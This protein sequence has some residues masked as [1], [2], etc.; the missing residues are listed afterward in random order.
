MF[1]KADLG[2]TG[3]I[4]EAHCFDTYR[5]A[6][7]FCDDKRLRKVELVVR[8]SDEYE[9]VV[10]VPREQAAVAEPNSTEVADAMTD[11]STAESP[12]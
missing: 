2:Q 8:V 1:I 10:D 5:D 6:F 7:T 3:L 9:F 4:E 12:S 11:V